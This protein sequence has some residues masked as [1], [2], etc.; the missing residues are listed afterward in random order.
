MRC[1]RWTAGWTAAATIAA[2][3]SAATAIT[4]M[5]V[6][7]NWR[8]WGGGTKHPDHL[9]RWEGLLF[10]VV[11]RRTGHRPGAAGHV[12][13]RTEVGASSGQWTALGRSTGRIVVV[14]RR[15]RP[16]DNRVRCARRRIVQAGT[17]AQRTGAACYERLGVQNVSVYFGVNG[18]E[19]GAVHF[20]SGGGGDSCLTCFRF[21]HFRM[22]QR[23]LRPRSCLIECEWCWP[24][25]DDAAN[26]V[27]DDSPWNSIVMGPGRKVRHNR[28]QFPS[29]GGL[30]H[31]GRPLSACPITYETKHFEH[32]FLY[33]WTNHK[34]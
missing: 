27:V 13:R 20:R 29:P 3:A 19:L 6:C 1:R 30:R 12:C 26:C 5:I 4:I 23:H 24:M 9:F 33:L 8:W 7:R 15:M 28:C 18:T 11:S 31:Q 22:G 34:Q 17:T 16:L 32:C 10:A 21:V 14:V 25:S 2:A